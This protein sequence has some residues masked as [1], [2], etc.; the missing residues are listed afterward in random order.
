[1]SGQTGTSSSAF[2]AGGNPP[3]TAKNEDWNGNNWA[4]KQI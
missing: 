4:E 1:M 3:Y 2:V